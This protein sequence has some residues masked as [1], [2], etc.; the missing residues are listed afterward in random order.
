MMALFERLLGRKIKLRSLV[1]LASAL[2]LF[3]AR[4]D[5]VLGAI[6]IVSA[7]ALFI[8]DNF[9]ISRIIGSDIT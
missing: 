1:I 3:I 8:V 2:L 5:D 4:R 6:T 9:I 7:L